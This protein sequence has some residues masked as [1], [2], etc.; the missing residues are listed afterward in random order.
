MIVP[1]A[2]VKSAPI[3]AA[4]AA[5][6]AQVKFARDNRKEIFASLKPQTKQNMIKQHGGLDNALEAFIKQQTAEFHRII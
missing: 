4:T 1:N 5:I 2:S 6:E 3:L